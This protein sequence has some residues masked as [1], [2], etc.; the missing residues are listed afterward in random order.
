MLIWLFIAPVAT[1]L[2]QGHANPFFISPAVREAQAGRGGSRAY[3]THAETVRLDEL[4]EPTRIL[5]GAFVV[6][7]LVGAVLRKAR[8][9]PLDKTEIWMAVFCLI[10]VVNVLLLSRRLAFGLRVS[11][12]A[13]IIPFVGYFVARRLVTSEDRFR[14]LTQVL[15][16][17]GIYVIVLCLI[18]R[19]VHG[20]ITYRVSGPFAGTGH[21]YTVLLTVFCAVLVG[22]QFLSRGVCRFVLYLTPAVILLTWSRANWVGFLAGVWVFMFLGHQ[23]ITRVEKV[24]TI[25]LVLLS[26]TGI[27]VAVHTLMSS[28]IMERRI[29]K[30]ETVNWRL[31]SWDL[32]LRRGAGNP[33]FGI[34]LNNS[35][36]VLG[37]EL[38]TY[39]TAHN[40]FVTFF[41]ELGAIGLLAY[42]A[43][44]AS[45]VRMGFRLYKMGPHSRDRWRGVA[46]IALM[47]AYQGGAL[48]YSYFVA[49]Q[50][51]QV[52]V[53]VF[54]GAIAGLYSR[55]GPAVYNDFRGTR[56]I[57]ERSPHPAVRVATLR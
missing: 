51:S 2:V 44:V 39:V 18:E 12:D 32:T 8:T 7:F 41:A 4:L 15:C 46:V 49:T 38:G 33:V 9:V 35:R 42:L 10:A 34:G 29:A 30:V 26:I 14:Q 16:Y 22:K 47:A 19:L 43:I 5:L 28:E 56:L 23:L 25:G 3:A 54:L 31:E 13:F 50:L 27:G 40:S 36:D 6:V 48:F 21:V 1:N 55:P 57:G 20:G 37:Q 24:R 45:I 53:Y 11:T 52:Y 17:M